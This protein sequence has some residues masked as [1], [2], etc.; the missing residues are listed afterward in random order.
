MK[1]P[2]AVKP[3]HIALLAFNVAYLLVKSIRTIS[4]DAK[5]PYSAPIQVYSRTYLKY[6]WNPLDGVNPCS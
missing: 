2:E 1:L 3:R 4:T 5:C 6:S